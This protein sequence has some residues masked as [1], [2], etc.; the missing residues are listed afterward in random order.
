ML[1]RSTLNDHVE[2]YQQALRCGY[3]VLDVCKRQL[4]RETL[5]RILESPFDM[6]PDLGWYFGLIEHVNIN[7][8]VTDAL[9]IL[10]KLEGGF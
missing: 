3:P 1:E 7:Y 9:G 4:P 8:E 2:I 10:D 5:D 6:I